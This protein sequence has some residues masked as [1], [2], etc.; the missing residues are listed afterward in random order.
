MD[1]YCTL[2]PHDMNLEL[3]FSQVTEEPGALVL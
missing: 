1:K 2:H 3:A